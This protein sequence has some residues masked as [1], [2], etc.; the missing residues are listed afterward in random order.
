V[1]CTLMGKKSLNLR[2]QVRFRNQKLFFLPF[3]GDCE[4]QRVS[5]N[6][7]TKLNHYTK[8]NPFFGDCEVQ[9]VSNNS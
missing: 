3:F 7:Y 6:S 5:N 1:R 9:R 4:V 2:H 8:L